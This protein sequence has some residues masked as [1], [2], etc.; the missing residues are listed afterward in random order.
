MVAG[1]RRACEAEGARVVDGGGR[2]AMLFYCFR[3]GPDLGSALH[4]AAKDVGAVLRESPSGIECAVFVVYADSPT[5]GPGFVAL[6]AGLGHV[7]ETLAGE[8]IGRPRVNAV[9]L[10]GD[11]PQEAAGPAV[12]MASEVTVNGEVLVLGKEA[13]VP[14]RT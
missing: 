6:K 8:G 1:I 14:A 7:V 5:E 11:G 10:A 9:M 12:F 2:A 3:A 13:G 4:Q